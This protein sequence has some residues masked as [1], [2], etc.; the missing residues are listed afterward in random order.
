[1]GALCKPSPKKTPLA[2][3]TNR[4]PGSNGSGRGSGTKKKRRLAIAGMRT[5]SPG[6]PRKLCAEQQ[7]ALDLVLQG[8]SIFITGS[9]GTGKTF[10]LR[11]IMRSLP[12]HTTFATASTAMA[13]CSIGGTTVHMFAGF[14]KGDA[15]VQDLLLSAVRSGGQQRFCKAKVLVIDEVSVLDADMFD[16]LSEVPTALHHVCTTPDPRD[17]SPGRQEAETL[18]QALRGPPV[19]SRGG[20]PPAAARVDPCAAEALLLR[21]GGVG[22]VCSARD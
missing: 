9:A 19:D 11:E 2:D 17:V 16:K 1:V 20:L 15:P 22:G 6:S 3:A 5:T 12:Q 4:T 14:G 8:C 18:R 21:G 7:H 13:A 10:L